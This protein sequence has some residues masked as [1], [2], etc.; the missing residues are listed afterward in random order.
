MIKSGARMQSAI[1]NLGWAALAAAGVLL[2]ASGAQAQLDPRA[3][4]DITADSSEVIQSQCQS[5]WS[6]AVE[7][8]QG[9]TRLRADSVRMYSLKKGDG[10]GASDRM[11]AEGQVYF[12][13]PERTVRADSAVYTFSGQTITLTGNVIVVQGKSVVRGDRLVI[14]TRTG[15]AQMSSNTTGRNQT[16]RV[17]GVFYPDQG[18]TN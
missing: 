2:G 9:R 3:P 16:G 18:T 4:I 1:G 14:N 15:Q 8:L 7:A 17:R 5:T 13:T 11:E 10:C 6:G 12:V